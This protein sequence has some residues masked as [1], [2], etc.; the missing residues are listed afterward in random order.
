MEKLATFGMVA[1][2]LFAGILIISPC[3]LIF[4]ESTEGNL[5]VWNLVGLA[6]LCALVWVCKHTRLFG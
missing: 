2:M 1:A 6:Y 5:T 4:T 3:F